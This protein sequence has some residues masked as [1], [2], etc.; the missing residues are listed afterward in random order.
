[1][2]QMDRHATRD[3]V[4]FD[5]SNGGNKTVKCHLYLHSFEIEANVNSQGISFFQML[6][7]EHRRPRWL[8]RIGV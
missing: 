4:D 3:G 7:F 1:M 5:D 6:C 8:T 2:S